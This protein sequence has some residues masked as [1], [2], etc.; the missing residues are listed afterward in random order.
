MDDEQPSIP[1]E[2]ITPDLEEAAKIVLQMNDCGEYTAPTNIGLYPHQWLWDS[3][4]TAVGIRHYDVE[5]AKIELSSLLR[6]Q[7]TNGMLPNMILSAERNLRDGN[8]WRSW[9]NP[10]APE[11]I[12]TSGITQPPMLAEAV[13]RVGEKMK[14][15]ERR[16]WYK[17]MYQ[18]LVEYHQW[19]YTERDPHKEGLVLQIHPWET[20][21]DNTPP[22]MS[23]IR[24]HDMPIWIKT[25]DKLNL[26]PLLNIFRRDTKFIPAEQR[27][28]TVDALSLYSAQRRL[29]RK[30][31]DSARIISRA[32]FVIED[33]TYNSI[34]IRA[35][36]HLTA[37]AKY[38]RRDLPQDLQ[39][40]M[41][42]TE[43]ALEA[44]WDPYSSQYYS[45][46]F[47]SHQLI[48]IPTIGTFMPLYAGTISK[49]RASQIV[50][51]LENEQRFGA[52]YPV[53]TVPLDNE[54][55]SPQ[56]YWQGPTW[57]NANWLIIDGLKRYGYTEHAAALTDATLDMVRLS[58]FYEYFS[59]LDG[60]PSGAS[61]FSWTA[62]LTIDLLNSK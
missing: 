61:N 55:F 22:W 62:A 27:M 54:W 19:L 14:A 57:V 16:T 24:E 2:Q 5:R 6:G 4:F 12:N 35:N 42:K 39:E 29:R 32:H 13:V 51:L 41:K 30:G 58:G 10:N 8:I 40:R 49:E 17:H 9:V 34:F 31:Y 15:P 11:G 37:I 38:I 21:L 33:V 46:E 48:K 36:Q 1:L 53:P 23:S 20:G 52:T 44:L 50:K 56:R 18:P 28:S 60:T 7:W 45:R 3:C 47:T 26:T 59:P 43:T 25:V